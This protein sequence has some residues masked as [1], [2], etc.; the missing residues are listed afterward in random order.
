MVTAAFEVV[1]VAFR[2]ALDPTLTLPKLRVAVATLSFG[3]AAPVPVPVPETVM[4]RVGFS[5]LLVS[6]KVP[7][8]YPVAVGVK[9]TGNSTLVQESSVI[10]KG[11]LP[12]ENALPCFDMERIVN[13][14]VPLFVSWME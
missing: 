13:A 4:A 14:A 10:G 5:A 12:D 3:V 6:V 8:V 11:K 2:V 1:S 7:S 9:V